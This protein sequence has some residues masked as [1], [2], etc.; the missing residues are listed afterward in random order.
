MSVVFAERAPSREE[1]ERFRPILSTYQD[2]TG[3]DRGGSLPGW[4]DYERAVAAAFNGRAVE[5]KFIFDVLLPVPGEEGTFYG[6]ACK[7]RGQL[8][9]VT[10]K[11]T[12]SIEVANAAGEFWDAVK[13]SGIDETTY[14]RFPVET[15]QAVLGCVES[16]HQAVDI[17]AG[18]LIRTNQSY[19]LVL[20]WHPSTLTYQLFQYPIGLP[21]V[22]D[23]HWEISGRRL[24][25]T[26]GGGTVFEWF[27][28]SGGQLK[29]Y[30][31]VTE[32]VWRSEPFGLEPLPQDLESGLK[33][34]AAAYF[35][36]A[37]AAVSN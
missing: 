9:A 15:A 27:A 29:Y 31:Q 32:A 34:K 6:L 3:G 21:N 26:R 16:W 30:P 23:F 4:R 13:A 14:D 5:S 8:S 18:S 35:P 37:W 28:H 22:A 17:K 2:G 36:A 12:V 10:R 1:I 7:K 24:L 20:Q 25:G 11:G 19:Y 33:A